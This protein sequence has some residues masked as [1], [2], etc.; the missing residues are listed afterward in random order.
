MTTGPEATNVATPKPAGRFY[1]PAPLAGPV[2]ERILNRVHKPGR[3][4]G[5]EWNSVQKDWSETALKWCFTYPDLYEIGMSN[6]GLRILYEVLN[7]RPDRLAERCFAPDV[8]FEAELRAAGV[9]LWSL[10]TRRPL[11][12]FDVVGLSLGFE[13]VCTNMLSMLDLA[14]IGLTTAERS[15]TDPLVI[16]G[17][18]IVLNPEPIADFVDAVVLGEG[19]DVVL[20]ISDVLEAIG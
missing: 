15:E 5:G 11:R 9:G 3:Y 20:E 13:L 19:E 12:E 4:A 6:L 2:V 17:G 7:D 8:D 18:S 1:D 16:A 10:E 14:G